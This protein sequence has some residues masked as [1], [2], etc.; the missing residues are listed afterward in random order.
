MWDPLVPPGWRDDME[1][2]CGQ[3]SVPWTNNMEFVREYY[4][5]WMAYIKS[6]ICD[7]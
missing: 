5:L 6:C 4:M 1:V 7:P 2:P 3:G